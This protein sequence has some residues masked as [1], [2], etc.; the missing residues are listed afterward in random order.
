[1]LTG[2]VDLAED[3]FNLPAR[4]VCLK[5]GAACLKRGR[6]PRYSTAIGCCNGQHR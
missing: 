5:M 2:I 6:N 3:M 4:I 1:M